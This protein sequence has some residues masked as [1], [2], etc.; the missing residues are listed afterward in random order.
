MRFVDLKSLRR[1]VARSEEMPS[2]VFP[3]LKRIPGEVVPLVEAAV[4]DAGVTDHEHAAI[5]GLTAS[6]LRR[7][8]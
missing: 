1:C 5:D 8:A 4:V 7:A 3:V 2:P 6:W